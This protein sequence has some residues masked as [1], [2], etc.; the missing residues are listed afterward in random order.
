M[1]ST[2]ERLAEISECYERLQ[3]WRAVAKELGIPRSTVRNYQRKLGA[4]PLPLAGGDLEGLQVKKFALPR[5]G[6]VK[7]YIC[8][9]AQNNTHLHDAAW[10]NLVA[11][12]EHY[13]AQ[14]LVA[15]FAYNK[16]AYAQY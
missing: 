6:Q 12:A 9:C 11:L 3:S 14:L 2:D 15:R 16:G 4:A 10:A 5:K 8:T 1:S 7:R 13:S